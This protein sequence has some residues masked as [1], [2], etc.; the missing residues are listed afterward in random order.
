MPRA[1]AAGTLSGGVLAMP[2]ACTECG[3]EFLEALHFC[4]MCG[5]PRPAAA[6]EE[7]AGGD[8]W[9][10]PP[11]SPRAAGAQSPAT[12]RLFAPQV[13]AIASVGVSALF[14]PG[15]P[16]PPPL[17]SVPAPTA[18]P[19]VASIPAMPVY[20]R[21]SGTREPAP[22]PPPVERRSLA[23]EAADAASLEINGVGASI[24][25]TPPPAPPSRERLRA[26]RIAEL[27]GYPPPPQKIQDTVAYCVRVLMRRRELDLAVATVAQARKRAR[28][29]AEAALLDFASAL[30]E[31][32]E[33]PRLAPLEGHFVAIDRLSGAIGETDAATQEHNQNVRAHFEELGRRIAERV[34]V[35][36][37][38][39]AEELQLQSQ[40]DDL[41]AKAQQAQA[42]TLLVDQE[43][44]RQATAQPPDPRRMA[45]LAAE[46]T[47][48]QA[49]LRMA[50]VQLSPVA[51]ELDA[52]RLEMAKELEALAE[53]YDAQRQAGEVLGE[54]AQR[55]VAAANLARTAYRDKLLELAKAALEEKLHESVGDPGKRA[56]DAVQSVRLKR[57][58]EELHV[59]ARDSFDEDG[60]RRGLTILVG[61]S[62]GAFVLL[63]LLILI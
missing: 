16:P 33:N 12:Q 52:K 61:T 30:L 32:R 55:Q 41:N 34:K 39:R 31:A 36:D 20:A 56:R 60:Y 57:D 21:R 7:G 5:A 54:K 43:I 14:P 13:P 44:R 58:E 48:R 22:A 19:E 46:R 29:E 25:P 10:D 63:A 42:T 15:A 3:A 62:L 40:F 2:V 17:P 23:D 50:E 6:A 28:D 4:D 53:L 45:A 38:L 24:E 37:E 49:Q 26:M 9:S 51:G 1:G 35:I 27:A 8:H 59:Q 18:A 11:P 47:S